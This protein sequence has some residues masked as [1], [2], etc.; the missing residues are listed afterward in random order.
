MVRMD[1]ASGFLPAPPPPVAPVGVEVLPVQ[2]A[3]DTEPAL[4]PGPTGDPFGGTRER[5]RLRKRIASVLAAI[6]AVLVK[7]GAYLKTLLLAAPKLKLLA[8][9]GTA[10]VSVGAYMLI[11]PWQFAVGLVLLLFIHEMGH[12]IQL[13]R[14]GLPA[15]APMFIPFLGAMIAAKSLGENALAEA[16]VGLAGPLLGTLGSLAVAVVGALLEPSSVGN[17]LLALGYFGFFIN[18]L[19][20]IPV[21][22]F[23]GGRAMAAVAPSMWFLGMA[24]LVVMAFGFHDLFLL[25]FILL[26]LREMPVRWRQLRSRSLESAAYYRVP[27]RNRIRIGLV[28]VGLIVVLA[29]GMDVATHILANSGGPHFHSL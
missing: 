12:V 10:L 9:A 5:G 3:I 6:A 16:R 18:L 27:R 24:G 25:I 13:R 14:E 21:V 28:Y 15:S 19:N 20:L 4:G 26:A 23:D 1:D 7:F 29:A 22:P 17:I 2:P 11:F 8:T